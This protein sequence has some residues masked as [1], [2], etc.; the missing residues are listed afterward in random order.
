MLTLSS[1]SN[2]PINQQYHPTRVYGIETQN[3]V[4]ALNILNTTKFIPIL[5]KEWFYLV[6]KDGFLVIDYQPNKLCNKKKLE[7]HMEWLCKGKYQAF[8]HGNIDEEDKANLTEEKIKGFIQKDGKEEGKSRWVRFVC[9]KTEVL[10][11]EEDDISKWTF[12]IITNGKRT[13]WVEKIIDSIR[14]QKIP[15]FEIIICGTYSDKKKNDIKY[16]SFNQKDDK[17]WITKKKNLIV[18]AAKYENICMLHDRI[19]LDKDWYKGMKEWGNC[20][21]ILGCQQLFEGIRV[22]DWVVSHYFINNREGE[23]FSFES[24]VDYR[25]WYEDI[26]FLGQLNIFKKSIILKNS[27]CWDERLYYGQREDYYFSEKLNDKGFI[28]RLNEYSKVI[29]LTNKYV[30]PTWIKY[31]PY[32]KTAQMKFNSFNSVLKLFTYISLKVLSLFGIRFSSKVLERI[33][34]R[35]YTLILIFMPSRYLHNSEWR[36]TI[37]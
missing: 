7:E 36:S 10:K 29:T 22:N 18:K 12:G 2:N 23:K 14:G 19:V 26:W 3:I 13:E 4:Y 15:H 5:L 33:R 11:I 27:L 28:H 35:I 9:Q 20:F 31:S 17:G 34:G 21:E 32:S 25:D 16:I 24:Y 6:K 8:F 37:K 30:N 1:V